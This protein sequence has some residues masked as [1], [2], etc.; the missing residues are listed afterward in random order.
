MRYF[1][2]L[3]FSLFALLASCKSFGPQT[4]DGAPGYDV[5]VS[6]IP[7]AT[8]RPL[9]R[10]RYGNPSSYNVYG[11]K[12]YVLNS[13]ERYDQ[14]GIASWYGTKFNGQLTSS[15]EPYDMLGMTGASPTLPIPTFVRVTNLENGRSVIVKINDRGPFAPNRILDLSYTAAKKLGYIGQGTA[16]VRVQA[17]NF[18]QSLPVVTTTSTNR[19]PRIYLQLGAFRIQSN[20][21]QLKN[22][23][24]QYT[25][26]PIAILVTQ[27]NGHTLYR[28]QVGPIRTVDDSDSLYNALRRHGFDHAVTVID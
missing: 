26:K 10:S 5:D 6:K 14:K 27:A 24:A 8:P 2:I 12:Y 4:R 18:N 16:L 3:I 19:V 22:K 17:I 15:R 23:A 9:P 21:Q 7:D 13:A 20:A 11:K 25:S 28:V 1:K